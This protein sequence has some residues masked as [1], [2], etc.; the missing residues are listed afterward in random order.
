MERAGEIIVNARPGDDV[1]ED[2]TNQLGSALRRIISTG[3]RFQNS[4]LE[5][6]RYRRQFHRVG[7]SHD[8]AHRV[9]RN[10]Q[11]GGMDLMQI[12]RQDIANGGGVPGFQRGFHN[13]KRCHQTRSQFERLNSLL[14]RL[15]D[16]LSSG[17]KL[18][19]DPRVDESFR[20]VIYENQHGDN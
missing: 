8:I 16:T 18:T 13:R 14:L 5:I 2:L 12:V 15:L 20:L 3:G 9:Q 19:C 4:H 6:G 1:S 10:K 11:V 7:A 17:L